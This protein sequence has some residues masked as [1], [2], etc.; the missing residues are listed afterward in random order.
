MQQYVKVVYLVRK[1]IYAVSSIV[2]WIRKD[3]V[4]FEQ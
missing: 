4:A 1:Y 3:V 2:R